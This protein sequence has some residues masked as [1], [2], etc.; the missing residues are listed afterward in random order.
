MNLAKRQKL[1]EDIIAEIRIWGFARNPDG[2]DAIF[3]RSDV[4]E[5]LNKKLPQQ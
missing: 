1:I 5:A 4:V 3:L 2:A